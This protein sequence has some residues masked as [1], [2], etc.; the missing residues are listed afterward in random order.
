MSFYDFV[1]RESGPQSFTLDHEITL[2]SEKGYVRREDEGTLIWLQKDTCL[3]LG[4][5]GGPADSALDWFADRYADKS[6]AF[7]TKA[8]NERV[9]GSSPSQHRTEAIYTTGYDGRS[10]DAFLNNLLTHGIAE[11]VDVRANPV[12]RKYGFYKSRI[13]Q[14]C[15][16]VDIDYTHVPELG[17]SS[18]DR[19]QLNGSA[20]RKRL[21][22]DYEITMLPAKTIELDQLALRI[23][24]SPCALM[25]AEAHPENC[26]RGKLAQ[27]L[28]ARTGFSIVHL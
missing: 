23:R 27:E 14:I 7:L 18:L 5:T 3:E 15:H 28:A 24:R 4:I 16:Q 1:P 9:S 2:L 12:S 19:A 25:C 6:Q 26:H 17:I 20:S 21:L 10:V 13:R 11:L 8:V 22:R